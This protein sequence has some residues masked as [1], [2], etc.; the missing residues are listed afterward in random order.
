M[1]TNNLDQQIS[2]K[3][4]YAIVSLVVIIPGNLLSIY[5]FIAQTFVVG[6]ANTIFCYKWKKHA[7]AET[8]HRSGG[9]LSTSLTGTAFKRKRVTHVIHWTGG[10]NHPRG[11]K[12]FPGDWISTTDRW[13]TTTS[14][15]GVGGCPL[16]KTQAL[17]R[18][19][20]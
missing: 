4:R 6:I 1:L 14:A 20:L 10:M 3:N 17:Y 7:A 9:I 12:V 16:L 5:T 15:R 8:A 13:S 11:S 2:K 19:V 18:E